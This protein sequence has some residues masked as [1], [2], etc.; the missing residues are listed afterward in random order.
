MDV[1]RIPPHV[2]LVQTKS[3]AW[4]GSGLG[5]NTTGAGINILQVTAMKD[6]L[7]KWTYQDP[8]PHVRI[9]TCGKNRT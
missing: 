1:E 3:T 4:L 8:N 9:L 6:R 5:F 2:T 7:G